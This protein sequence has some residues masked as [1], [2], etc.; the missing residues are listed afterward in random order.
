M[1]ISN[2]YISIAQYLSRFKTWNN[3]LRFAKLNINQE[4]YSK[5]QVINLLQKFKNEYNRNPTLSDTGGE[6][7]LPVQSV[8]K[9]L[10]GSFNNALIESGLPINQT[11]TVLTGNET[12]DFCGS[13]K[14]KHWNNVNNFRICDK[15][16]KTKRDFVHGILDPNS[17]TGMGYI[18]EYIA[19]MNIADCV[20]YSSNIDTFNIKYDIYNEEYGNIDVKSSILHYNSLNS[21]GWCFGIYDKY[22]TINNYIFIGFDTTRSRVE[23]VWIIPGNIKLIQGKQTIRIS[24]SDIGLSRFKLYEIDSTNFNTTYINMDMTSLF[25]FRNL[26]KQE[27]DNTCE[28]L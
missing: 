23:H 21:S 9:R 3:S 8:F 4:M 5:E 18:S 6:S 16:Y 13:S 15:C 17:K 27:G 14:T 11:Y 1:R 7:Y 10:F 24:N 20:W 26:N 25:P 19:A 28:C 12:C 22:K 2:G